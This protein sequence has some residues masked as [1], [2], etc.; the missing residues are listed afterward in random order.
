[1]G[2]DTT[3][4]RE[5]DIVVKRDA[6]PS[7]CHH[8][9]RRGPGRRQ[10]QDGV[11]RGQPRGRSVPRRR[12]QGRA[13]RRPA[14]LP[15]QPR[16]EQPAAGQRPHRHGRRAAAGRQQQRSPPA[17]CAASRTPPATATW[18]SSPPASTRSADRERALVEGLVRRRVDG[19]LL[20]PATERQ[21]YLVRRA[22]QRPAG[23]L[24]R[25]PPHGVDADSVTVD[26]A[27]GAR[28]AVEHLAGPGPPA[29]R[30]AR[31]PA[32]DPDRRATARRLPR[33]RCAEAR[34]PTRPAPGRTALRSDRRGR[35]LR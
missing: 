7:P 12:G 4:V 33:R 15:P 18:S 29:H 5:R 20:M 13:G 21:D 14:R 25:P 10:P 3:T 11:T 28:L 26:N 34:H 6:A 31:R 17:C 32:D 22:A 16:R 19:L 1:M 24:R 23:R 30:A 9:R 35:T 8:A 27:A 2:P